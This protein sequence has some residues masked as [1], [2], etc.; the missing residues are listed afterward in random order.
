MGRMRRCFW[1][2]DRCFDAAEERLLRGKLRAGTAV[3]AKRGM[4]FEKL[5]C[6]AAG[7]RAMAI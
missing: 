5:K 4:F 1:G 6:Q 2:R 3:P 7:S